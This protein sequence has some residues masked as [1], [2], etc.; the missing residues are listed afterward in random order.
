MTPAALSHAPGAARRLAPLSRVSWR[1]ERRR[2]GKDSIEMRGK[3]DDGAGAFGGKMWRGY[4]SDD[5][6]DGVGLNVGETDF[7][8]ACGDPFGAGFFSEGRRGNGD[9][10]GLAID[11]GLGIVVHPR[12]RSMN[13]ALRG[14]CR[15]A[16][17][18]RA[19]RE[20]RHRFQ[21]SRR[22]AGTRE[23]ATRE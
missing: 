2:G 13:G 12:E 16:S 7:G 21:G 11:E 8:E 22:E 10:F 5:V 14:D 1:I 23:R 3:N 19:A 18:G 17:E 15:Y 9:E 6:A 4:E 20:D